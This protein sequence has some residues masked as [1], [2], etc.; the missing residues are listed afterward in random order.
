MVKYI[1]RLDDACETQNISNW[2]EIEIILDK[3]S[4]K[5]IVGVIPFNEDLG[6]Q[7]SKKNSN[8]W[9]LI[10]RWQSKGWIIALHGYNHNCFRLKKGAKQ[11][12]PLNNISEFVGLNIEDQTRKFENSLKIFKN[13][14]VF[15]KLFMAPCHSLNKL[16]LFSLKAVSDIRFITDGFSF[17]PYMRYGFK[18]IPQ[19]LW[20]YFISK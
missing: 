9:E 16:T 1:L 6:L 2:A 12:L 13:N 20:K 11:F 10:Q 15:P 5:P 8:F 19:Q 17:R 7:Y 14:G 3:Y 4:I 18:W